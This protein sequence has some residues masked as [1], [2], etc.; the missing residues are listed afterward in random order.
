V[1]S[2]PLSRQSPPP[3]AKVAPSVPL[4][5]RNVPVTAA[6]EQHQQR[7]IQI[8]AAQVKLA[9]QMKLL[10]EQIRANKEAMRA[11]KVKSKPVSVVRAG[12]EAKDLDLRVAG[13]K[14]AAPILPNTPASQVKSEKSDVNEPRR[15]HVVD[16]FVDN[17]HSAQNAEAVRMKVAAINNPQARAPEVAA[18]SESSSSDDEND[19]VV[20]LPEPAVKGLNISKLP[21]NKFSPVNQAWFNDLSKQMSALKGQMR[22]LQ[23]SPASG[24]RAV[25]SSDDVSNPPTDSL[26]GKAVTPVPTL[27][28]DHQVKV[29]YFFVFQRCILSC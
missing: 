1:P 7:H 20:A 29:T 13:K 12:D 28:S 11:L 22:V 25:S 27:C 18:D 10:D 19:G 3:V 15:I 5:A 9:E 23:E 17:V 16:K 2:Q 8:S 4:T 26:P 21:A 6:Q 14:I 24:R